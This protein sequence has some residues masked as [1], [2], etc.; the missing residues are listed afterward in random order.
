[1]TDALTIAPAL[2]GCDVPD[3]LISATKAKRRLRAKLF[4]HA[5][6]VYASDSR[7][8]GDAMRHGRTAMW[9]ALSMILVIGCA[10]AGPPTN[11]LPPIASPPRSSSASPASTFLSSALLVAHGLGSVEGAPM[12]Y[13]EYLPPGYGEGARPPLLV[14]LHGS[15]ASGNG[16][17]SAVKSLL[18]TGLPAALDLDLWPADRPFVVLMPQHDNVTGSSCITAYEVDTFLTF[19]LEHYE[20]DPAR[21]YLTGLS[22]GASGTW[23]YLGAHTDELVA[24]AVPIAG[25]GRTAI[26]V[27]GCNLGK[28]AIWAFHGEQDDSV[29][30]EGSVTPI[31]RLKDCTDPKPVDAELTV[32][33]GQGHEI[34][35]PIYDTT[36][37]L[38]VDIYDW[39]LGF[40]NP[41]EP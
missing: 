26:A 31:T 41:P 33:P 27:A 19:A 20:V 40:E 2:G 18:E 32:F 34:W 30:L 3:V 10:G 7:L 21:V 15:G 13:L 17:E 14:F 16:S 12:G 1:V 25:D 23:D 5:Q 28:V 38:S 22:C 9:S 11:S 8:Y 36:L 6:R 35:D 4:G 24:A 29:E 37:G 39:M